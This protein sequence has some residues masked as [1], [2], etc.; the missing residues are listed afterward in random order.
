MDRRLSM[1]LAAVPGSKEYA[2]GFAVA[3]DLGMSKE[4][5]RLKYVVHLGR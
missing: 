1:I 5:E 3:Y 2:E 4:T